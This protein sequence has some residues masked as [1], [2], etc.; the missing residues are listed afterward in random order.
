MESKTLI[1][2]RDTRKK[3]CL[4]RDGEDARTVSRGQQPILQTWLVVETQRESASLCNE[5]VPTIAVWVGGACY[6]CATGRVR[7]Q[8]RFNRTAVLHRSVNCTKDEEISMNCGAAAPCPSAYNRRVATRGVA[9]M[10]AE[11]KLRF[12]VIPRRAVRHES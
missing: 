10:G 5:A 12:Q 2:K 7:W 3:K 4:S 9:G 11:P 6:K 1:L 8:R